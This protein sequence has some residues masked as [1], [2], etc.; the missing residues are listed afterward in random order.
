MHMQKGKENMPKTGFVES[1]FFGKNRGLYNCSFLPFG[2]N[3]ALGP[4]SLQGLSGDLAHD[5]TAIAWVSWKQEPSCLTKT[6]K[7]WFKI[8]QVSTERNKCD[9]RHKQGDNHL[10]WTSSK[11]TPSGYVSNLT[12]HV[13]WWPTCPK[14]WDAFFFQRKHRGHIG[15]I[16]EGLSSNCS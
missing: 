16:K 5:I 8:M 6:N 13:N 12:Q 11:S 14:H 15:Y 3:S 1:Q 10:L 2:V 7:T 4:V 9:H